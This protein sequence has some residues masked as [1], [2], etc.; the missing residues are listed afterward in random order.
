MKAVVSVALIAATIFTHDLF[1]QASSRMQPTLVSPQFTSTK[2]IE[3][4]EAPGVLTFGPA[5]TLDANTR[6]VQVS[7]RLQNYTGGPLKAMQL[8]IVSSGSI[9]MQSV[10][11]GKDIADKS[12]WSL[13]YELVRGRSNTAANISDTM[14]IVIYGNGPNALQPGSYEDLLKVTFDMVGSRDSNLKLVGV[15]GS[16]PNGEKAGIAVGEPQQV[17]VGRTKK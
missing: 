6:N 2:T 15:L 1:G 9:K 13:S 16:L 12:A 8:K 3:Q 7:I 4:K 17:V 10:G 11:L 5:Q 14:K